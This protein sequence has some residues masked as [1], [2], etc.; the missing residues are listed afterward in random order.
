MGA[1]R[2]GYRYRYRYRTGAGTVGHAGM[3]NGQEGAGASR[4]R[5]IAMHVGESGMHGIHTSLA[6]ACAKAAA[7]LIGI[8]AFDVVCARD[9]ILEKERRT[10]RSYY[11]RYEDYE[12]YVSSEN[13]R[14]SLSVACC[15]L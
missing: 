9:L 2:E 15:D 8:R 12:V 13:D 4:H 10:Q 6:H 1:G 3:G 14:L 11:L 7:S 5:H